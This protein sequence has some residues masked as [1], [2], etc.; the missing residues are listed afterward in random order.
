MT[1][2]LNLLLVAAA[3]AIVVYLLVIL[4]DMG[5][6]SKGKCTEEDYEIA[7]KIAA[8]HHNA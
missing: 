1:L 5:K 7:D 4:P 6:P 3:I 8:R 2:F